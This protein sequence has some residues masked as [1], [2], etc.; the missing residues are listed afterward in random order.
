MT[1]LKFIRKTDGTGSTLSTTVLALDG[2]DPLPC[3]YQQ[4]PDAVLTKIQVKALYFS[5]TAI[6]TQDSHQAARR[7]VVAR[8]EVL[9]DALC[10][11]PVTVKQLA[12]GVAVIP[13][14]HQ[15]FGDLVEMNEDGTTAN[16]ILANCC[17]LEASVEDSGVVP[18]LA[19]VLV[20]GRVCDALTP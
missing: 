19:V 12:R 14:V 8:L 11:K 1:H 10:Y 5:A 18:G 15:N 9:R 13:N 2:T 6:T 3:D 17:L 4:V 16:V 7:A 20:F